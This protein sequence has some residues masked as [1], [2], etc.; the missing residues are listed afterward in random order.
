MRIDQITSFQILTDK[1]MTL[2]LKY[3]I[4]SA[5]A[6]TQMLTGYISE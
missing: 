3:F 5:F 6:M 2:G 1:K 4:M